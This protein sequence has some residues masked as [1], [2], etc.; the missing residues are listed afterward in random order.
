M[1]IELSNS[2]WNSLPVLV[3]KDWG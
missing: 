3:K 2:E 1:Y